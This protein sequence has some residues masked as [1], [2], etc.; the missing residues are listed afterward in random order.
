MLLAN[1]VLLLDF[2][3]SIQV[4]FDLLDQIELGSLLFLSVDLEHIG[5]EVVGVEVV[6]KAELGI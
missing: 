2:E 6:I 5:Y 1:L 3:L 4:V